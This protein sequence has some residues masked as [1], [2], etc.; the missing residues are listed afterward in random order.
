M[1]A[2]LR[3][4]YPEEDKRAHYGLV[5]TM[6]NCLEGV[7]LVNGRIQE[8]QKWLVGVEESDVCIGSRPTVG[9]Q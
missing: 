3:A 1:D 9:K 2:S 4:L 7:T 6:C 8:M 5:Y